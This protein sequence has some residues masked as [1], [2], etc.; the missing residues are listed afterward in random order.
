MKVIMIDLD[1]TLFDTRMVN[2]LSYQEAIKPIGYEIDYKYFCDYCNGRNYMEFLPQIT[3]NNNEIL[4]QIHDRK[5]K[6]Y[7][8]YLEQAKLNQ[9][10]IDLAL[11][12]K[13]QYKIALVTMASKENTDDILNKFG[14]VDVFDLILTHDDMTKGKPDPEC[15]IKV[16]EHYGAAPEDCIIFEDSEVGI[17]AAE[18]SGAPCFV[19][20]GY[21]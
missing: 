14:I 9:P 6:L 10:L 3:T 8:E 18:R 20:R 21:N 5:K 1:G 11:A 4:K 7:P 19:V 15:Y 16:M 12:A 17:E 2:W 13:S